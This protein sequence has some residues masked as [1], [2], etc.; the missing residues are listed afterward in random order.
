MRVWSRTA[1]LAAFAS[2]TLPG[3]GPCSADARIYVSPLG[4]DAWSGR[5]ASPNAMRTDG[6]CATLTGAR[7]ALRALRE[8]QQ[9]TG[10]AVV[11]VADGVYP[12][13]VPLILTPEDSGTELGP[14]IY[15]AAPGARPVFDGGRRI[16][17]FREVADGVWGAHV[18]EVASGDWYFEQLWVNGR[19]A[20][21]A[22]SPNRFYHYM[23][24]KVTYGRDPLTGQAVNL[25]T[26]AFRARPGDIPE[27]DDPTD[28]TLVIYH[29]WEVSR[30]RV[31]SYDRETRTVVT[32]GPSVWPFLE[33]ADSQRYHV[34][35]YLGALDEPGEWYL[36]RDGTL[37]YIPLPGED[38]AVAEVV[39]PMAD[40][41]ITIAGEPSLGLPVE[42]VTFSGLTF[43]H[44]RYLLPET[45][46]GDPQAAVSI[47]AVIM[48]DGAR[49]IRIEDCEIAHTGVWG[50]WF[51]RGCWDCRIERTYL[52]DL[53]AGGVRIGEPIIRPEGPERTG[54]I[55]L[56]N[57]IIRSGGRVFPGAV[58]VWIGQS[59]YNKVTNNDISDLYYT[60]ISVGWTWGYG[61]SLA[62]HNTIDFNHIHHIGWG[63]LSDMGG[64]Y[65]LGISPGTT[66]SNNVIHDVY[67]YDRYGRGGWGLYND[68]GSSQIVMEN[69]LVYDVS[70][71]TY[72]QHYGR[73]NVIRN[74]I[75]AFSRDGQLQRSRVEPHLSFTL[76]GNVIYWSDGPLF[77]GWW[78][79]EN[80]RLARNC[81]WKTTGPTLFG[82]MTLEEWQATG[83][84]TGSIV[85]DPLFTNADSREF[86]LRPDSPLE[87]IGFV[88]FDHTRAGVYG[89][90]K[91]VAV[92]RDFAY[93]AVEFAPPPPPPPPLEFEDDFEA[94]PIGATPAEARAYTEGKAGLIAVTADLG[95]RGSRRSLAIRDTHGLEHAYNPHFYYVPKHR[96]GV[97]ILGF[98]MRVE[99]GVSM[100]VEWRDSSAPYNVGPS[101]WVT[102]GKLAIAGREV[103]DI[104]LGEWVRYTMSAG[105]GPDRTGTW[106]L[107]VT[108]P[109][110]QPSVFER[111]AVGS[112]DWRELDWLGFTSMATEETVFYLDNIVLAA[113]ATDQR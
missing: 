38:M 67:S 50:I 112:A 33:W 101:L 111:L 2:L 97:T 45:G 34:E 43:A 77:H 6:P 30:L 22:R 5:L 108:L 69:N 49:D 62:V 27:V 25:S 24:G 73:E 15:R 96:E 40:A 109:G 56:H 71:G 66:V 14:T 53:G 75:L 23:A 51:R 84:D 72:H 83:K 55:T 37:Y 20:T 58:G 61:P 90:E 47:P 7:D 8:S 26:R 3:A 103:M 82:D 78:S 74:N 76:E 79:D 104:P 1:A 48:A 81:Y 87:R 88:P 10:P 13:F 46:H 68:E 60:G 52:H 18:P 99:Q 31:A 19:R 80:V 102:D 9:I 110:Q 11:E 100:Y 65:T 89:D 105:V 85:A 107:E 41:F 36:D 59:G 98:D 21:R 92:A 54:G 57:S 106:Q 28:L 39:A 35:N 17:G 70:T 12:M 95:A 42:H 94:T 91:W 93:P 63:V 16:T 4:D 86:T 44:S 113:G 29:S 32:T 64:V